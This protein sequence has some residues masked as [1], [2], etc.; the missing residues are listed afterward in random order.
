MSKVSRKI[1][2]YKTKDLVKFS[3]SYDGDFSSDG[4]ISGFDCGVEAIV[5]VLLDKRNKYNSW[6]KEEKT[7]KIGKTFNLGRILS[8]VAHIQM[9][10]ELLKDLK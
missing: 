5:K 4:F 10:D 2:N 9:I 8:Y 3:A 1:D 7:P 6:L